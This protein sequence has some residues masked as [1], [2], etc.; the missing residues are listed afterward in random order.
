MPVPAL[1]QL[2]VV[3][4]IVEG[5]HA[6]P[7]HRAVKLARVLAVL[8]RGSALRFG[9]SGRSFQLVKLVVVEPPAAALR[10]AVDFETV[11][12]FGHKLSIIARALHDFSLRSFRLRR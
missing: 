10:T 12:T 9:R 7:T 3:G 4:A 5:G 6:L 8:D 11:I 2:E 1:V